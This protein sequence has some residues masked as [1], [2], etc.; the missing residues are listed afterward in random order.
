MAGR[1]QVQYL[2]ATT[3]LGALASNTAI[4][5][6]T[7]VDASRDQGVR[8]KQLK[9]AYGLQGHTAGDGPIL[10]GWATELTAVEIAEALT[11]DP[12][13]IDD[14]DASDKGNRKVMVVGRFSLLEAH[15]PDDQFYREVHY[16]WKEVPEGSTLKFF[17][18][19]AGSTLTTGSFATMTAVVVQEWLRD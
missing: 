8:I 1:Q 9:A 18:F 2:D 17:V 14:T 3:A 11:A 16:P 6:N 15:S 13:G 10:F 5:V 7:N 19:N 12:Q 4:I